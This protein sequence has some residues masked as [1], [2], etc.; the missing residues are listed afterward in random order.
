MV[1]GADGGVARVW[2]VDWARARDLPPQMEATR[3]ALVVEG[4]KELEIA[5]VWRP[6]ANLLAARG[7]ETPFAERDFLWKPG[8]VARLAHGLEPLA[9]KDVVELAPTLDDEARDPAALARVGP[10]FDAFRALVL[11]A[12]ARGSA[13]AGEVR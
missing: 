8:D 3:R 12:A 5:Q 7:V 11:D 2:Q 4:T 1:E 9:W 6:L 13:L 10:S